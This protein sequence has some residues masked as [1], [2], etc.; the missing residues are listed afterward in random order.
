MYDVVYSDKAPA[1]YFGLNFRRTF[2][3]QNKNGVV[4]R[5]CAD[6]SDTLQV[7]IQDDLTDLDDFSVIAQ[8][9]IVE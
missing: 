9:H 1:G 2:G 8:G 6:D 4:I 3:G 5:L 7:I